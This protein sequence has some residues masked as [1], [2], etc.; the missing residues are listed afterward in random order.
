MFSAYSVNI[1]YLTVDIIY[2]FR[3]TTVTMIRGHHLARKDEALR[4]LQVSF[5]TLTLHKEKDRSNVIARL[6]VKSYVVLVTNFWKSM[7]EIQK[8]NYYQKWN[9]FKKG[10]LNLISAQSWTMYDTN[11]WLSTF[12]FKIWSK[13]CMLHTITD[14]VCCI[15]TS[16]I[17]TQTS[18]LCKWLSWKT[19]VIIIQILTL[20]FTKKF[21]LKFGVIVTIK[22]C[23]E[24]I[25]LIWNFI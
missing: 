6:S 16:H 22:S 17:A 7:K 21:R 25:D 18:K 20:F 9:P 5:I 1:K 13:F 4:L 14:Y 8:F 11:I 23:L 2:I 24:T 10:K 12:Y 3:T 19:T 15:L